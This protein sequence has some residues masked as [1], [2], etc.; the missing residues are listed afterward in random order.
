M[1]NTVL[2]PQRQYYFDALRGSMMLF[3]V[4]VHASLAD[5]RSGELEWIRFLS[6][7][8][9]MACFFMISGYFSAMVYG[10]QPGL[11]FVRQRLVLMLVPAFFAIFVLNPPAINWMYEFW[12]AG[13]PDAEIRV[14]WHV[15]VWFLLSLALYTLIVPLL[16]MGLTEKIFAFAQRLC[17][18]LPALP[19]TIALCAGAMVLVYAWSVSWERLPYGEAY[20]FLIRSTLFYLPFFI[21]GFLMF[22]DD[23]LRAF[24]HR[25][26]WPTLAIALLGMAA[27]AYFKYWAVPVTPAEKIAKFG[28]QY[29]TGFSLSFLILGA[30]RRWVQGGWYASYCAKSSYTI[31]L[32]HYFLISL[33]FHTFGADTLPAELLFL[34]AAFTAVATGSVIQYHL[35][36]RSNIARFLLNGRYR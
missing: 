29:I 16:A 27:C 25:F 28:A 8:F 32:V 23:G 18:P 5:Q 1:P 7:T 35:V 4:F 34:L 20:Q 6:G 15:H 9:R 33:I 14:N 26:D 17:R 11:P 24:A 30:G 21:F 22:S 3:G 36:E 31:Y 10:K 12:G 19:V 13:D 2:S